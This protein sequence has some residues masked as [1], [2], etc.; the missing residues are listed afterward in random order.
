MKIDTHQD[1]VRVELMGLR[2]AHNASEHTVRR[3]VAVALMKHISNQV[4]EKKSTV[5]EA[6]KQSIAR[7]HSLIQ[8]DRS[9]E[10]VVAQ[11]DF[12]LEAQ[13]DLIHRNEGEQILLH[14]CKELYDQDVFEDEKVFSQWWHDERAESSEERR[15]VKKSSR[16][17]LDWLAAE[18]EESES[19]EGEED[20]GEDGQE[21]S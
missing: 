14:L 19:E 11:I 17:F 5:S 12:L 6:V 16:Q 10:A 8:R 3:S 1:D 15:R 18:D 2:F 21:E 7:Y 13:K 20:E 4:E 9:Q